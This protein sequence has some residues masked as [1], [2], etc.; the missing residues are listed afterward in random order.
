[1]D[2]ILASK[3]LADP[4]NFT[5]PRRHRCQGKPITSRQF[6]TNV[7]GRLCNELCHIDKFT[8]AKLCVVE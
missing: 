7:V 3:P 8:L 4:I 1:M 2:F 6:K 5:D